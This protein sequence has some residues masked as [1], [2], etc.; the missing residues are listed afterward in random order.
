MC[1]VVLTTININKI[2]INMYQLK[3]L[4]K[5]VNMKFSM[6]IKKKLLRGSN[7]G[8]SYRKSTIDSTFQGI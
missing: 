3:L 5:M 8:T 2:D 6:R 7:I 4:M 1:I